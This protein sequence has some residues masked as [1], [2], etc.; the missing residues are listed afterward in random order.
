MS[1]DKIVIVGGGSSGYITAAFLLKTYPDMDLTLIESPSY[2]IVGVGESTL[3]DFTNFRDYFE[4]DE[5]EFMKAT[6]ASY[7]FGI[8]FTDF[9]DTNSG[10]FHY[11]FRNPYLEGT[12]NG[13]ADWLEIKAFYPET[14][15]Q[16]FAR[17]YFPIVALIEQNKF[18]LNENGVLGNYNPYTDV[19]YHFDATKFGLF[20]RDK[21]CLP[22]GL[23]IISSNVENADIGEKGIENLI[24]SNGEKIQADLFIDCTGFKSLLLGKY[25][26]EPFISYNDMLP[27]N[28]AWATQLAYKDKENELEGVTNGT[29]IQNG[30]VWNIPLWSRLGTG[31]VY[32]DKYISAEDALEEF[33]QYLMSD[34]MIIPRT[35]AEVDALTYKDIPMRVGRHNKTWV[36]NVV[37]IGLSAG[38][39]EPLE[40]NGLFSVFW[41]VKRLAK[42]LLRG[43][44]SQYDRDVFNHSCKN[45]FETFAEFVAAHY[46]LSVRRDTPYWIDIS[47]RVFSEKLSNYIDTDI[48]GFTYFAGQ[49]MGNKIYNP[50]D[51][52]SY[53]SVGM[54]YPFFDRVDQKLNVSGR[55]IK[56]YIDSNKTHFELKKAIWEEHIKDAPSLMQYLADNIFEEMED[57]K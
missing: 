34:K 33:K 50:L 24:L 49:K 52:M 38:F 48:L 21:I 37:A 2:P 8:K 46:T 11:P 9:Y 39:V 27:N 54:N 44:V 40:S 53:I 36:K 12:Q 4:L 51:G 55:D 31:Y 5:K 26:E 19:T 3:A 17:S 13:L 7:K 35:R 47:N 29:A 57:V 28:R 25:M 6:D 43:S 10:S 23:K 45:L 14:P 18:C 42:S 41:Y 56:E 22:N 32:S 16:D 30:W 20:L 1:V 15:V